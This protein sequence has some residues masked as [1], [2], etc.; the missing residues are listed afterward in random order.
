[1]WHGIAKP[2][3]YGRGWAP[4]GAR[5]RAFK[6][7][8]KE[9]Q[10]WYS[11]LLWMARKGNLKDGWAAHSYKAKFGEWPKN[12]RVRGKQPSE[13]VKDFVKQRRKEYIASRPKPE[14]AREENT[15]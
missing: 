11:G 9:R 6:I 14:Q 4:S 13:A 12:L 15:A 1:M 3:R 10:D 8:T 7:N 5:L 2:G